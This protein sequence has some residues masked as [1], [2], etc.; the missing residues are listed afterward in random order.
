MTKEEL[1]LRLQNE[2]KVLRGKTL[3]EAFDAIDRRY[4]VPDDYTVEAYEDYPL[5]IGYGQT[6]SQPTTVFFMLELLGVMEGDRVLD[7][8]SGSGWTTALLGKL[9]GKKGVVV[10]L[11][12]IQELVTM[13]QRNLEKCGITNAM[14]QKTGDKLGKP[15]ELFDRILVSAEA[16]T[17]PQKLCDQLSCG[18]VLVVPV[19][20]SI[21][22]VKKDVHA[23]LVTKK[24]PGF[25]FVPLVVDTAVLS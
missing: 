10:G 7:V 18:G 21:I 14:I 23:V 4:F 8:G 2:T 25:A 22:Q 9:A 6:I 24:Y 11:E 1:R 15:G 12:R 19:N 20:G 17:L 5:P 3:E 13:G 16:D